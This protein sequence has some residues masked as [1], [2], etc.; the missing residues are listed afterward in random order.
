MVTAPESFRAESNFHGVKRIPRPDGT[1]A[2]T[3]IEPL[4]FAS[5]SDVF[6][7][8]IQM[9]AFITSGSSVATGDN[10]RAVAVA[11]I[12]KAG[13]AHSNWPTNN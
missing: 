5:A 2:C 7:C 1:V 10:K 4:I 9:I 8:R 11:E 12:P 13:P 6:P 3:I